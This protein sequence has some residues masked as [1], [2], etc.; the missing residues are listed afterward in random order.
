MAVTPSPAGSYRPLI[1]LASVILITASLYLAQRI[2][3]PLALAMLLTFI[4][5]PVVDVLRRR[6]LSQPLAAV[7]VVV[8]AL[9][10][11]AG[12]GLALTLQLKGLADDLPKYKVN[13]TAKI[14]SLRSSEEGTFWQEFQGLLQELNET[15]PASGPA[16]PGAP[17][18]VRLV[19]DPLS[20][21]EALERLAGPVAETL[22]SA[23]LVIVLVIF[24]LVRR[25]DLRDRL[26]RLVAHGQLVTTTRAFEEGARRLSRFLMTQVSINAGFGVALGTGL[27]LIGVPYPLLWGLLAGTLRFLPYVG[28]VLT[29]SLL[30]VF[31]SAVFPGWTQPLLALALIVGLELT[32]ANVVEPVLLGRS[33]GV[34]PVALLVAAAFWTWLWGPVGL[35]LSAPLTTCLVVLGRYVPQ[36]E[37]MGVLLGDEPALE[38][39]ARFY[40]RLLARDQDEATDQVEAFIKGQ[41]QATVY[42]R[43]LL[44]ALVLARRDRVNGALTLDDEQFIVQATRDILDYMTSAQQLGQ[45]ATTE[46]SP[47]RVPEAA[48]PKTL[49]IGCPARDQTD[50]LAVQ[51]LRPLLEPQGCT[52]EVIPPA[53]L[54]SGVV[55]QIE[56][57]SPAVV[58]IVALPPGGLV[59]ARSLC[60]RL[61]GR[62]P[63][64]KVVVCCWGQTENIE[65]L[66]EQL[67]ASG[68][69][70]V[71]TTL[72][73]TRDYLVPLIQVRA[74]V[75][76][77]PTTV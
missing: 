67:A 70:Q 4:L 15:K 76:G 22:A 42:D 41:E 48:R 16:R 21:T 13:I 38:P 75:E 23:A 6:R 54:T 37:F 26:L 47:D 50:E 46:A 59:Q 55:P 14:T 74:D 17:Q 35:V 43:V 18:E 27:F 44:P 31:D 45:T 10:L 71:L 34:S 62:F 40:Q 3:I 11:L 56:K 20:G 8:L 25:E 69:D 7:L 57:D 65:R 60:K 29:T 33:T 77:K 53:A 68:A 19:R 2:I 63:R 51:M 36:L 52:V 30:L 64:L 32:I 73:E 24:M 12:V 72:L 49:V 61:R 39:A 28:T 9:L 1:I 66:R 58:C 5:S